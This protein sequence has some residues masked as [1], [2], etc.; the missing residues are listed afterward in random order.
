MTKDETIG[1]FLDD[2]ASE[3]PTPGG[4][5]AAAVMG[6]IGAALVSM[7]ANLTIGKK[8]YESVEEDLKA[9]RAEAER[10]RAELTAAIDEDVVAFNSVMGAYGLPRATDEDKAARSAAIQAALKEATLA[11]LRAVKACFEV[12]VLSEAAADKGNLNVISDAGVA[13]LAANAGLR[14]AALNVY[15]NAKAIK[16]REFAEKQIGEVEALLA[17]A[18]EKTEAVYK[19]VRDKIGS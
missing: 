18:A 19:V 4:G 9:A 10:V 2:L 17:A 16:D 7:V 12:I 8:N 6:A 13:V 14:S 15:I 1:K 11:P 3:R 5:G